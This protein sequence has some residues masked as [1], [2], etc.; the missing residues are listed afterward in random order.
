MPAKSSRFC[1]KTV[2]F[3]SRSSDAARGLEDRA[4][5]REHL[6]GLLFDRPATSSR[7]VRGEPELAGDEH[8]PAALIA[9]EYGAPWNG[10]G[11][12]SVRTT[13]FRH[14]LLLLVGTGRQAWPSA[15]PSAL[16]IAV[17]HVLRVGAL[18]QADVQVQT[19]AASASSFR[20]REATSLP[21]PPTR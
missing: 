2:V 15:A 18:E 5:V 1:R 12:A 19:R 20:N 8:E 14:D 6:L 7:L 13:S 17:E 10:A 9:C 16:K 4:Q 11:A 3:T 21:S